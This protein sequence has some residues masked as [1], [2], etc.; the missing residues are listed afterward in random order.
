[1]ILGQNKKAWFD[2]EILKEYEAGIVL[3]G[4]EVKSIKQGA[5]S[6]KESHIVIEKDEA[7]ILGFHVNVW[8]FAPDTTVNNE[9]RT[10]KLLL[11]RKEING[12]FGKVQQKGLTIVPIDIHLSRGKIK[13]KIALAKGKNLGDKRQRL[14]EMDQKRQIDRDLSSAGY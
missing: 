4:W 2:F 12:L 7:W 6:L 1:M 8:K 13:M 10:R 9:R 14:K 3:E 11:S 5:F